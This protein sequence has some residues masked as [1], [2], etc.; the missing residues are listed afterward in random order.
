MQSILEPAVRCHSVHIVVATKTVLQIQAL[1]LLIGS[2]SYQVDGSKS[3]MT[4]ITPLSHSIQPNL[5]VSL[6]HCAIATSVSDPRQDEKIIA[7]KKIRFYPQNES[8]YF[9]ALA[10]YR[11]SYNLAVE[12]IRNGDHKDKS[13]QFINMRPAIKAQVIQKQQA[14][15]RAYN[16][17]IS[18]N[19]TLAASK[20]FKAVC[21]KN[22]KVNG[23]KSGCSEIRF[24]RRKGSV[25]SFSLDRL[26]V[27]LNPCVKALGTIDLTED[28]SIEA[29]DRSCTMTCDNGRWF[30]QRTTSYRA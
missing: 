9:D 3:W 19:G 2:S 10:L 14:T 11:R 7:S 5:S 17:L 18:D 22:K 21:S 24:K 25:H 6:P 26:S 27:G 16:S 12:R 30:I 23:A 15:G 1:S 8:A 13:S 28:V 20:T 4:R 29:I